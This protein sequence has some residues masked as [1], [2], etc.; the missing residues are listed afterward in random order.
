MA[1]HNYIRRHAQRDLHFNNIETDPNLIYDKEI[2][3]DNDTQ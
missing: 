2:K 3:K 1:L